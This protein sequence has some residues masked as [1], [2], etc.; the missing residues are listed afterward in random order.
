[1]NLEDEALLRHHGLIGGEWV[2]ADGG[3]TLAVH[4]PASGAKL[5]L[6]PNMGGCLGAAG[7]GCQDRQGPRG[8]LAPLVRSHR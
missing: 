8:S 6:I 7:V 3:G 4:N 1:L 2:Q 5:G